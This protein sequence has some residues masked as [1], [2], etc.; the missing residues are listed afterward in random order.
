MF[1]HATEPH[2][3]RPPQQGFKR[4]IFTIFTVVTDDPWQA[5]TIYPGG[6][7]YL[8]RLSA[9]SKSGIGG[10]PISRLTVTERGKPII[11]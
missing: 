8:A 10:G 7:S 1:L 2:Q 4:M 6:Y 3:Q 11:D 5:A 9:P